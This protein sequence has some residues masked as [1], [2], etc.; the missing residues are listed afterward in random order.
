MVF[1]TSIVCNLIFRPASHYKYTTP[2]DKALSVGALVVQESQ[3]SSIVLEE[4]RFSF[5]EQSDGQTVEAQDVEVN[6]VI[7]RSMQEVVNCS[8]LMVIPN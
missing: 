2:S 3:G 8:L 5:S 7:G 4:M 1:P 6:A